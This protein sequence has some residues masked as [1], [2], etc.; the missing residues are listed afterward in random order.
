MSILGRVHCRQNHAYLLEALQFL[1]DDDLIVH[2][3]I[4]G[5]DSLQFDLDIVVTTLSQIPAWRFVDET[6]M[7]TRWNIIILWNIYI[8]IVE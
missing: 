5:G 3:T 7:I 8:Y 6:L 4:T 1:I 2:F